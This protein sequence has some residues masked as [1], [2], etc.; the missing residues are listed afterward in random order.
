MASPCEDGGPEKVSAARQRQRTVRSSQGRS[1]WYA[2]IHKTGHGSC[3]GLRG[4]GYLEKLE[5]GLCPPPLLVL[6]RSGLPVRL[7]HFHEQVVRAPYTG[8][9]KRAAR[10]PTG[11]APVHAAGRRPVQRQRCTPSVRA[12]G[13]RKLSVAEGECD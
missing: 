2:R 12:T 1:A 6:R 8:R 11:A 5:G 10:L 7:R 4:W 13:R 9:E 3:G